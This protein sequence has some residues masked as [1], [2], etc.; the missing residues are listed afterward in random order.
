L[1]STF[2]AI[3][4]PDSSV[5]TLSFINASFAGNLFDSSVFAVLISGAAVFL[6]SITFSVFASLTSAL[7]SVIFSVLTSLLSALIFGSSALISLFSV[8]TSGSSALISV[9]GV[10]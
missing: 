6:A 9:L 2:S 5:L 7:T 4:S 3:F 10:S 8:L 1:I